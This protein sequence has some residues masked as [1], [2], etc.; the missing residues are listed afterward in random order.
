[1]LLFTLLNFGPQL[2]DPF[3]FCFSS[4]H[5]FSFHFTFLSNSHVL[6]HE[7]LRYNGQLMYHN[8][9]KTLFLY[10]CLLPYKSPLTCLNSSNISTLRSTFLRTFLLHY[11]W[12]N[13]H[14]TDRLT[15]NSQ[16]YL[17]ASSS[18]LSY[19]IN[20]RVSHFNMDQYTPSACDIIEVL[21][22]QP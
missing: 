20:R 22:I 10:I 9:P 11:R 4:R 13:I 1:M 16:K 21:C 12:S 2:H 8:F 3:L 7:L 17:S 14:Q 6:S 5:F 15:K 19:F 18:H